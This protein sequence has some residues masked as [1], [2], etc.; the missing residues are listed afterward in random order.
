MPQT[1]T[2]DGLAL[3]PLGLAAFDEPGRFFRRPRRHRLHAADGAGPAHGRNILNRR[4][5]IQTLLKDDGPSGKE[6][7]DDFGIRL[8]QR[9]QVALHMRE[10]VAAIDFAIKHDAIKLG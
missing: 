10:R 7:L 5:G 1:L 4:F 9:R 8:K 2:P 6:L 3:T